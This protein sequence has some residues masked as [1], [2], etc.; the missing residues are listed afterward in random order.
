[1]TVDG[2]EALQTLFSDFWHVFTSITLPGTTMTFA[3]LFLGMIGISV[4]ITFIHKVL[5][6]GS[7]D[8]FHT[9]STKFRYN[10]EQE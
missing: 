1:M 6:S 5:D 9:R 10:K 8:G 4:L 2:K 3:S 7:R